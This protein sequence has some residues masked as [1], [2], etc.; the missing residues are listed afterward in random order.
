MQS[1]QASSSSSLSSSSFSTSLN[2]INNVTSIED[3]LPS[4]NQIEHLN[5]EMNLEVTSISTD[6]LG[7]FRSAMDVLDLLDTSPMTD[8]NRDRV[9]EARDQYQSI[10]QSNDGIKTLDSKKS[11]QF[12]DKV[13]HILENME[14]HEI[15][16][17]KKH[18]SKGLQSVLSSRRIIM[19]K[20]CSLSQWMFAMENNTLSDATSP[21]GFFM[22][23]D[24]MISDNDNDGLPRLS[25]MDIMRDVLHDSTE[26]H[27]SSSSSLLRKTSIEVLKNILS[28]AP[29]PRTMATY[30]SFQFEKLSN[31]L[32][33]VANEITDIDHEDYSEYVVQVGED[34]DG[35]LED[36]P[37][38]FSPLLTEHSASLMVPPSSSA[39]LPSNNP[40]DNFVYTPH[41]YTAYPLIPY[42]ME[43]PMYDGKTVLSTSV[44]PTIPLPAPTPVSESNNVR[45]CLS[46]GC[47]NVARAK[48]Y[49]KIH[50]GGRR[51]RIDG[52]TKS[53]QTGHLCI[54]H[55]GGRPCKSDGCTKTAQSR[56]LCKQQYVTL[57]SFILIISLF[58]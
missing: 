44:L 47:N 13:R 6:E 41:P 36:V 8:T 22:G 33:E 45:F 16:L 12:T 43:P 7:R 4:V 38:P 31:C 53:A 54:A 57:T 40:S 30:N 5:D 48:N 9:V 56:G 49:C 17:D 11:M 25:S 34:F 19:E 2:N 39:S 23:I 29:P 3:V 46:K 28:T 35:L 27:H 18:S 50:G 51:C 26:A 20:K 14:T 1:V 52:C 42:T 21:Q 15:K 58:V 10:I 32:N 24:D 37:K 55:G